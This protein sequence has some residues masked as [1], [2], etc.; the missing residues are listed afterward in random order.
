M[1]KLTMEIPPSLPM[2]DLH[3]FV[4]GFVNQSYRNRR[5]PFIR[6]LPP[7]RRAGGAPT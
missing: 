2:V 3:Q 5:D 1:S 7:V 6:D 4:L